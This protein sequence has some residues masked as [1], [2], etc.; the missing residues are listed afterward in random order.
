MELN[1]KN[2]K[3]EL[4]DSLQKVKSGDIDA[5]MADSV[6]TSAREILR[7]TKVQLAIVKQAKRN[8]PTEV[9]DFAENNK[10]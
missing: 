3:K 4:W 2:L 5:S 9:I 6:A 1:A 10:N 7:T 8:V